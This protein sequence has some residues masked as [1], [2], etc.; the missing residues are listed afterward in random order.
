VRVSGLGYEPAATHQSVLEVLPKDQQPHKTKLL[1]EE[2][3]ALESRGL[4]H[5]LK[6][7]SASRS[8]RKEKE[9]EKEKDKEEYYSKRRHRSRSRSPRRDHHRRRYRSRS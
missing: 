5:T 2:I 8:Y 4:A 3:D 6:G 1:P 7:T 9:K